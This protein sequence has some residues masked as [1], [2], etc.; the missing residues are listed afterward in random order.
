MFAQQGYMN[1]NK[2]KNTFNNH[3]VYKTHVKARLKCDNFTNQ[4]TGVDQKIVE[5]CKQEEK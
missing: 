1:W 4:W 2:A 3:N 5:V